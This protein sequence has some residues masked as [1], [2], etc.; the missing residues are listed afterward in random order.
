MLRKILLCSIVIASQVNATDNSSSQLEG[1]KYIKMLGKTLKGNLQKEMKSDMS[2]LGAMHF[3]SQKADDLTKEVNSKLPKG[4][5]IRRTALRYRNEAN[6]PDAI[7]RETMQKILNDM[8]ASKTNLGK[9]FIVDT[10]SSTRIYKAL[11]VEKKCLKCHGAKK[12][13]SSDIT[14]VI[15]SKYPNDLATGFKEGDLRGVI[16]VETKK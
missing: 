16:V 5:T 11:F 9:P 10:N 13:I 14:K 15:Q 8:N 2:G 12:N 7:D 6:K 1:V 3:C 4:T